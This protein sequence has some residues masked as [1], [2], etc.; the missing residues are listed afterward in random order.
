MDIN[1]H[2]LAGMISTC[3]FISSTF[4]MLVKAYQ[5]K[6]LESYSFSH[7]AMSNGGNVI[8]WGYIVSLPFGPI[9]FL[10]LFSTVTTVLMLVWYVQYEGL[11][12]LSISKRKRKFVH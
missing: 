5:S 6:N 12:R 4:P 2:V 7:I 11:P 3:I 1:P 9:W 8:N 10:H